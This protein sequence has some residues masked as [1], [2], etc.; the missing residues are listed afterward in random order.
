MPRPEVSVLLPTRDNASTLAAAAGDILADAG[1]DLELVVIDDGSTDETAEIL[2]ELEADP[3]VRVI[4]TEG[5]GIVAALNRGL[6][7]ARAPLIARMD[8]DDRSHPGRLAAQ[9]DFLARRPDVH[10]VGTQVLAEPESALGDGMKRYVSWQN[11]LLTPEDHHR[12]IFVES[13]LCHPSVMFRREVIDAVGPYREVSWPEDYDLWLRMDAAGMR[14]AKLDQ[15]LFSWRHRPGRLTFT[16]PRYARDRI[17]AAKGAFLAA[18]VRAMGRPLAVWGAGPTGRRLARAMEPE[19]VRAAVFVDIDPLK[20]GRVAR[21]VRVVSPDALTP[22]AFAVVAAV[23]AEG[24]R[25]LIRAA[26]CAMGFV[27]GEDFVVA[28]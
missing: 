1:V 13:P 25:G 14:L 16:H 15:V 21:G 9:R 5:E 7:A 2:A 24:A 23:G 10:L 26:L 20:I 18:R 17:T 12:E 3:R 4:R 28:A 27:E 22:S 8:G 19:G 11:E 6:A